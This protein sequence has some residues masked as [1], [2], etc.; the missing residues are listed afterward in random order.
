MT[1]TTAPRK[2]A[3]VGA[4]TSGPMMAVFL[5]RRGYEV[6]LYESRPDIRLQG[7]R[8][9]RSI[10]ITLAKRGLRV[11]EEVG[12]PRNELM[13]LMVPLKGRMI[14]TE[15]LRL[16]FQPYGQN[17][18]EVIYSV[19]RN[20]VNILL[21]N[22][23]EK[24]PGVKI[25]FQHRCLGVDK[26]TGSGLIRDENTG[27]EFEVTPE[28][29]IGADGTFS[30]VRQHMQKGLRAN[31]TQLFLEAGY[32]EIR[33]PAGPTG[34]Y[35]MDHNVLH[36]WPRGDCLLLAMANADGSFTCTCILPFE[37]ERSFAALKSRADVLEF[38]ETHFAD[39]A[40]L[41]PNLAED[42]LSAV[43]AEFITTSMSHWY[44]EDKFVLLGDACHTVTPFYGQG[45]N[46]AFEDCSAL[47][48]CI[49]ERGGDWR[50]VFR[51]YQRLRKRHTDALAELSVR[52]YYELSDKVRLPRV[53][54]QKRIDFILHKLFPTRWIPLYTM[55]S[56]TT[57]SYADAVE[58]ARRQQR[59]LKLFGAEAVLSLLALCA[60]W[61]LGWRA[62]PVT[63]GEREKTS[64]SQQKVRGQANS[65]VNQ[66][67][68]A[69]KE[70]NY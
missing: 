14:H 48:R 28:I 11:L 41:I 17:E 5:A 58:R 59:I 39:A 61:W 22:L 32:R 40:P 15:R 23:A 43:P 35:V 25:F 31:Y 66:K 36:V 65:P 38:F 7:N 55:V 69:A 13:R 1:I 49:E 46:A 37:G 42:F 10:N 27:V 8:A 57:M 54:L 9:G 24:Q 16:K 20:D 18:D 26:R 45:M 50:N 4:G 53:A 44:Y 47:N 30:T 70:G 68:K 21:L 19:L 64:D 62:K 60:R 63:K 56:H 34:S 51:E 52:N 67:A 12:L 3:I 29:L 33:I 2:I 6:D